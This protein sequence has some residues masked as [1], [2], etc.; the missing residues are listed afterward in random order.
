MAADDVG[1]W[2]YA[3]TWADRAAE[4]A[5]DLRGVAGEPVRAVVGGDLAA[6]VGTVQLDEFRGARLRR[7]LSD[8]DAFASNARAHNCVVSAFRRGGPVVPV[9]LGTI[10][11]DD[12]RVCQLL[13]REHDDMVTA[14]RRV[15]GR[16]E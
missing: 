6:A 13:L 8:F 5:P 2:V 1:T 4:C 11:R 16:D 9:R 14:L 7:N 3:I 15:S 10:Y 12:W